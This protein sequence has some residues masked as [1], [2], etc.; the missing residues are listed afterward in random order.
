MENYLLP[1]KARFARTFTILSDLEWHCSKHEL[2]GNQP[3]K[4]IQN[5]R[6]TGYDVETGRRRWCSECQDKQTHYR[7][8]S[9]TPTA[10]STQ[11]LQISEK[12]RQRV[13]KH[14]KNQ[15]AITFRQM[16]PELLEVDHRFPHVRWSA[17]EAYD[18]NMSEKEL[19]HKFQLLTREHNLWKS[20]YCERCKKTRKRG[21]FIGINFFAE[22][23]PHWPPTIPDDDEQGCFGCFWYNPK[24]W[25]IAL[26][27]RLGVS[28]SPV[29][30]LEENSDSNTEQDT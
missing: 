26:N 2:P 3:A 22:G 16:N 13:L 11:R 21:T 7:L 1:E 12:L 20:R 15:N 29:L 24:V 9:S 30:E 10:P 8:T 5:I 27:T 14:Y 4:T 23:G 17:P 18:P 25:Q 6:N 19:Y 28:E